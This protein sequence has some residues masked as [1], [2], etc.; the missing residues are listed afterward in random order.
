MSRTVSEK[1]EILRQETILSQYSASPHILALTEGFALRLDPSP[2]LDLFYSKIFDI[3]TAEGWGL[4]NWGRI[5]QIGRGIDVESREWFGFD[6]SQLNPFN[7]GVF[8]NS[9]NATYYYKMSDDAY[10]RLLMYKAA[11]NISSADAAT[12]NSLLSDIF[13]GKFV[14]ALETGPMQLRFVFG[15][16]LKPFDRAILANYGILNRGAGVGWE[17][18]EE[19][20]GG[21]FGFNGS[22]LQPFGQGTFSPY[23]VQ[24]KE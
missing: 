21:V 15:F 12:L 9:E 13:E 24:N 22:H 1:F 23:G 18:Y 20:I 10:R 14:C 6:G 16:N 7:F 19:D 2:D 3:D 5:L 17:W 4:D 8:Y 11:S